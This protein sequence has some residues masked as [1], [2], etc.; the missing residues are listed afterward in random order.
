MS[1]ISDFI[2]SEVPEN[3]LQNYPRFV[4]FLEKYYEWMSRR[5]GFNEEETRELEQ[6]AGF[7][8]SDLDKYLIDNR[9]RFSGLQDDWARDYALIEE[10]N[11]KLPEAALDR[12]INNY[13][14][15]R[16]FD[17]VESNDGFVIET[18]D[19]YQLDAP[20]LDKGILQDWF[21]RLGFHYEVGSR[22]TTEND[23]ILLIRL[24]KHIHGIKGTQ[25]AMQLFFNIYFNEDVEI[26]L[27]KFEIAALDYNFVLDGTDTLRDDYYYNEFTYV[28]RVKRPVEVYKEL[29]DTVYMK[30]FHPS[31][32]KVFL[33]QAKE[34]E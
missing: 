4:L 17:F 10:S 25:H 34:V 3:Y 27:P 9:H 20:Y 2:K 7:I 16:N 15:D 5:S 26:Y 1:N 31:G 19:A 24:I 8:V 33:E 21:D 14:V 30:Y 11:I 32:F 23:D 22:D 12:F 18:S 13:N 6:D 28:I 29:F